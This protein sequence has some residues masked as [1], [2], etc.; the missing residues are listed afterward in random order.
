MN[1]KLL[2]I[3]IFLLII[4][5]GCNKERFYLDDKYYNKGEYIKVSSTDI[6]KKDSY[7]L[8]TYNNYCS[9]AVPCEDIFEEFMKEYK[10]DFLS[11]PFE[12]FK[13]TYLYKKVK[14]AP[15]I[16]VVNK[17]S[18]V[19][20]LDANNETDLEKYQNVDIFRDWISE[21]IYLEKE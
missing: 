4:V 8:F 10:I 9:L 3:F 21:Y 13:K 12:E 17:G 15:S 11:M 5:S 18:V 6:D 14:Y 7:V 1:K 16:I 19:S 2:A 20:F